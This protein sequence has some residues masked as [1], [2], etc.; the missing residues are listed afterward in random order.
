MEGPLTGLPG[1]S[2][3]AGEGPVVVALLDR[4][5]L[6]PGSA[7]DAR[8]HAGAWYADLV[9]P[10]LVPAP[11]IA[12]LQAE[13]DPTQR[14]LRIALV[15]QPGSG[16]PAG[17]V[18]LREAR[19]RLLDDDRLELTGVHLPLPGRTAP[20]AAMHELLGELDF[21][22]PAWIELPP[23]PGWEGALAVLAADG[24]ERLAL[25]L[26]DDDGAADAGDP[27]AP[28]DAPR[29]AEIVRAAVDRDL[30]VRVTGAGQAPASTRAT[31]AAL[32]GVRA[33]L[34]GAEAPEIAAILTERGLAPLTAALR[35]MSDADAAV[36]RAFLDGVVV[37]G[38]EAIVRDLVELGLV[39][40]G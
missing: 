20:A 7:A 17:L 21:T 37:T 40:A 10:L 25:R 4:L 28:D 13:L 16:D 1:A 12:A 35:R 23:T 6:A 39:S 19:D 11:A 36:A 34:N 14:G 9:G 30:S 26:P 3:D 32:C 24:P 29:A 5:L 27:G 8:R 18:G 22:V 38:V 31:L 15:A 33:A 2:S